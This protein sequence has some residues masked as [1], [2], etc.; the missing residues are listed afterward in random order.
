[1]SVGLLVVQMLY[2]FYVSVH[3]SKWLTL[4]QFLIVCFMIA[5][6]SLRLL[7]T[8]SIWFC[9]GFETQIFQFTSMSI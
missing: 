1:M 3:L 5:V 7:V 4:F 9:C 6:S 8:V 2:P